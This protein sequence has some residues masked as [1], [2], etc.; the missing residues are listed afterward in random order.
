MI[1]MYNFM[2]P[3]DYCNKNIFPQAKF[4]FSNMEE[5]CIIILSGKIRS[6]SDSNNPLEGHEHYSRKT[7]KAN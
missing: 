5:L 2:C 3:Y 7:P 4:F 1:E 6:L